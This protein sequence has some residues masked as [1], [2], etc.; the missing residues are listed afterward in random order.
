MAERTHQ[1]FSEGCDVPGAV[2]A[3]VVD[4]EGGRNH[5][6][7]RLG[8]LHIGVNA[9]ARPQGSIT[10]TALVPTCQGQRVSYSI[11]VLLRQPVRARHQCAM[12]IPEGFGTGAM[13]HQFRGT[14]A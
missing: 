9:G 4:E 13:L 11:E 1:S 8:T 7:A 2:I 5:H 6:T 14:S 12:G 3:A 10:R